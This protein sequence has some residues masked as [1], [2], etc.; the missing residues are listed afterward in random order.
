MPLSASGQSLGYSPRRFNA[1]LVR[2]RIYM[3]L[4][5]IGYVCKLASVIPVDQLTKT[6]TLGSMVYI[7]GGF[8]HRH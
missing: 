4:V 2:G 1:I 8:Q 5:S 6:H 3:M 7:P